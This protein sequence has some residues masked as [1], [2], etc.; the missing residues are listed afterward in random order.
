MTFLFFRMLESAA[1]VIFFM[2]FLYFLDKRIS[3]GR[4]H[5]VYRQ[6]FL[7]VV[8]SGL[9]VLVLQMGVPVQGAADNIQ[10]VIPL[11]TGLVFGMPAGILTGALG[12][13]WAAGLG[14]DDGYNRGITGLCRNHG[15]CAALFFL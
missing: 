13:V 5:Q 8:F 6:I 7:G 2:A 10:D 12:A 3:C 4:C 11:C 14:V 1:L 15:R 9:T